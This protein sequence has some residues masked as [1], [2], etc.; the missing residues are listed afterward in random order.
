MKQ[1]WVPVAILAAALFVIN[2]AA[3]LIIR[4]GFDSSPATASTA[5]N[6]A[7][8]VMFSVIGLV[9]AVMAF[10]QSQRKP[11]SV[12][13]PEQGV[14]AISA[15]LLTILVGP[16]ISGS[17]PFAGGGD[18]FFSQLWLYLGFSILGTLLGYWIATALGRDYRS[19]GLKA[20]ATA[21]ANRPRR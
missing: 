5:E 8:I 12:W 13:V 2:V 14:A 21:K 18:D 20:F 11:P 15:M 17:Q 1:R 7:S 9:L 10:L 16:F 3:R 4:F 19:K 6:R